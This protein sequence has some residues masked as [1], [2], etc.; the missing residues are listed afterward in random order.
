MSL[1]RLPV[2]IL[3]VSLLINS[4]LAAGP[5]SGSDSTYAV[6]E[7]P[8]KGDIEK[9]ESGKES[10][11]TYIINACGDWAGQ[12]VEYTEQDANALRNE[13][14]DFQSASFGAES[15]G[16]CTLTV[17]IFVTK[18]TPA[19]KYTIR[20]RAKEKAG[21]PR[22]LAIEIQGP[23][24]PA[25][26][27][28][29]TASPEVDVMWAVIP[30]RIVKDNYGR[31]VADRY[32]AIEVVIGNNSGYDLQIVG[33]GFNFGPRGP[34]AK[35]IE[36]VDKATANDQKTLADKYGAKLTSAIKDC[37]KDSAKCLVDTR[38]ILEGLDA[39]LSAS[40]EV[41]RRIKRNATALS[42]ENFPNV[43]PS[44][45]Y[46]VARGTATRGRFWDPRHLA[47]TFLRSLG[48]V[49][50][51]SHFFW[52]DSRQLRIE[53]W[54]NLLTT[55]LPEGI[56]AIFPDE[57]IARLQRLDDQILRDGKLISNNR[58]DRS[59]V[60]IPKKL[61]GLKTDNPTVVT[62]ALGELVIIG[63]QIQYINRVSVTSNPSGEI[64]PQP[65]VTSL[66]IQRGFV[67][68]TV[69]IQLT[70]NNLQGASL[71]GPG[72]VEF[73]SVTTTQTSINAD[74]TV[75]EDTALG[76]YTFSVQTGGGAVSLPIEIR[77][78]S[79]KTNEDNR[80]KPKEVVRGA[81]NLQWI[82]QGENLKGVSLQPV[83]NGAGAIEIGTPVFDKSRGL[84][85]NISKVPL[86][87][88][89]GIYEFELVP[90]PFTDP[91]ASGQNI[92]KLR[93]V[94]PAVPDVTSAEWKGTAPMRDPHKETVMGTV[95]FTGSNFSLVVKVVPS[96][97]RISVG[98]IL[99]VDGGI[100]ASVTLSSDHT[101]AF[102]L[103]LEDQIGQRSAPRSLQLGVQPDI[104]LA[105]P[106]FV[107]P[108]ATP[109][110]S[111]TLT[112]NGSNLGGVTAAR[113]K[114]PAPAGW[115]I[116]KIEKT[117]AEG[118][119]LRITLN[120]PPAELFTSTANFTLIIKN[121]N[122]NEKEILIQI[123]RKS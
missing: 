35:L 37:G 117:T 87:T 118:Q 59:R 120:T 12:P 116:D 24:L 75:A 80:L 60:L 50:I 67:G 38:Q 25:R 41:T 102:T 56:A 10:S 105:D 9:I 112:I 74:V 70:G 30:D 1:K 90:G 68:Q 47:I 8:I 104:L 15:D 66:N 72:G 98:D 26:G 113:F 121:T 11:V 31:T 106:A 23:A 40:A 109:G 48:P 17:K 108:A 28:I 114:E 79:P 82:I 78:N 43:A 115:T 93:V 122:G 100:E 4:I 2:R 13:G 20:I 46:Q 33:V 86:T 99:R 119:A 84:V 53:Q 7:D 5:L 52:G 94:N 39:E 22:T 71:V 85:V 57:T 62:Q 65:S 107:V 92:V 51:G 103:V 27:P 21:Q 123:E 36:T 55:P 63:N 76:Q 101:E 14:I 95:R 34:Y 3:I 61:L 29:P 83:S 81:E 45:S 89:E 54:T 69:A 96:D 19:G 44:S 111:V 110:E 32:Y 64:T 16:K 73:T 42:R 18:N 88:P 49:L 6:S 77:Q 91:V 97:A 58:Q